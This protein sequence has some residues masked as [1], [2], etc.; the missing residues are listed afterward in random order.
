MK[1]NWDIATAKERGLI[2]IDIVMRNS[3]W[4]IITTSRTNRLLNHD[5]LLP[6]ATGALQATLFTLNLGC[7][8]I[9]LE[10]DSLQVIQDIPKDNDNLSCYELMIQ[11]IKSKLLCFSGWS[12]SHVKRE[13]NHLAHSLTRSTLLVTDVTVNHKFCP[14]YLFPISKV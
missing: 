2:G 5:P 11:D 6:E 14:P 3:A 7:H 10:G 4:S 8:N 1:V 9:I 13:S 12:I